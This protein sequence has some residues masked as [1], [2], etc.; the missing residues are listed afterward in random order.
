MKTIAKNILFAIGIAGTVITGTVLADNESESVFSNIDQKVGFFKTTGRPWMIKYNPSVNTLTIINC[1]SIDHEDKDVKQV[2]KPADLENLTATRCI[3]KFV[4]TNLQ[5]ARVYQG[6]RET[7]LEQLVEGLLKLTTLYPNRKYEGTLLVDEYRE[8]IPM[9]WVFTNIDEFRAIKKYL[10][11]AFEKFDIEPQAQKPLLYIQFDRINQEFSDDDLAFLNTY[12]EV[13]NSKNPAA[14]VFFND[15]Q[16][17]INDARSSTDS[18]KNILES[19]GEK[20]MRWAEETKYG[21]K[22]KDIMLKVMFYVGLPMLTAYIYD[23]IKNELKT[24]TKPSE[25]TAH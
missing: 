23:K 4:D 10:L 21:I 3:T 14:K 5:I 16:Q 25:S 13:L 17:A 19:S 1:G 15:A 12:Y 20:L 7:Y 9:K 8:G 11:K 2:E 22:E 24:K 18:A 6:F